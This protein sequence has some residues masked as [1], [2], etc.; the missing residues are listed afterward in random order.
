MKSINPYDETL[1]YCFG[2]TRRD[3]ADDLRR[4]GTSTLL[5]KITRA[6]LAGE[7]RCLESHPEKR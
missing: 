2:V 4:H 5:Q 6:K 1:C 3:I 7:C